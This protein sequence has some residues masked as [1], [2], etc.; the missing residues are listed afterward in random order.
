MNPN[1][2]ILVIQALNE[3]FRDYVTRINNEALQIQQIQVDIVVESMKKG[4]W[5]K[6][7]FDSLDKFPSETIGE[8]MKM[9][10]K[11]TKLNNAS[12]VKRQ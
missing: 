7:F 11:Y 5:H 6:R 1:N 12:R 4:I 3:S 9:V 8:L 2:L 10:E